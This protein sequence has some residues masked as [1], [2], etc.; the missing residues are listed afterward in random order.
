MYIASSAD[1]EHQ[2][3]RGSHLAIDH[4][5]STEALSFVHDGWEASRMNKIDWQ[6]AHSPLALKHLRV[7]Y[8]NEQQATYN[9]GKCEKCLRTMVSLYAAGVLDRAETFPSQIDP[10]HLAAVTIDGYDD[11]VFHWENL[12]ALR[13]RGL[14]PDL[15]H[16]LE[17][18]L[19]NAAKR[20]ARP[21]IVAQ[22]IKGNI[23]YLDHSYARGTL[24]GVKTRVTGR[25]L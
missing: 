14:A 8:N 2:A 3:L 5:W 22:R 12:A 15:Q 25:S 18:A 17:A 21:K 10:N 13:A 7:C 9:C 4:L 11:A 1:A 6:I 24:R 16:A 23:D 20:H 19:A